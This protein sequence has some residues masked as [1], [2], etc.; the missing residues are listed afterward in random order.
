[1]GFPAADPGRRGP[2][3]RT[4]S[5]SRAAAGRPLPRRWK[6]APVPAHAGPDAWPEERAS[7][8]PDT[9]VPPP[10]WLS[11]FPPPPGPPGPART[12]PGHRRTRCAGPRRCRCTPMVARLSLDGHDHLQ[13]L[14]RT[15]LF[16]CAVVGTLPVLFGLLVSVFP[17]GNGSRRVVGRV[18]E[19]TLG[20][21]QVIRERNVS[22]PISSG[23]VSTLL[24]WLSGRVHSC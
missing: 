15:G 22:V 17:F 2:A 21:A 9:W 14:R 3:L 24:L 13:L 4:A 8:G 23:M 6:P 20:N 18:A 10:T 11:P 7:R 16:A 5:A 12:G 1:M 19:E